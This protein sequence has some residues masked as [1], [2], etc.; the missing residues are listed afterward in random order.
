METREKKLYRYSRAF[1]QKVVNE[2]ECGQ[3]SIEGARKIYDIGGGSTINKWIKKQGKN[4]LLAKIV[5]IEMRDEVDQ[6]KK[7]Q[8]DKA[9]LE[10]ALAKAHLKIISLESIIESAEKDLGIDLKKNTVSKPSKNQLREGK[11]GQ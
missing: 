2:I 5:R 4:H 3:L 7:L 10:S 9:E 1:K 8:K 6:L 11:P